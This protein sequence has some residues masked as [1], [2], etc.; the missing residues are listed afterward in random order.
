MVSNSTKFA[1]NKRTLEKKS[2]CTRRNKQH[3]RENPFPVAGKTGSTVRNRKNRRK[4]IYTKFQ[5]RFAAEKKVLNKSTRS[6]IN[7]KTVYTSHDE[8]FDENSVSTSPKNLL[9]LT[10][11]S[12]KI[13]EN[14]FKDQHWP[15]FHF[16]NGVHQQK[17]ALNKSKRF[18]T[19]QKF[20]PL[21][22]M[23]NQLKNKI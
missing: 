12:A 6:E 10:A 5:Q 15:T 21:A 11:I 19:N 18:V 22:R 23:K 2:V 1:L 7:R 4:L 16:M 17:K 8:G 14:G 20:F 9:P 13:Q 3:L